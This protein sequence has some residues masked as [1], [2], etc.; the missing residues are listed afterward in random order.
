[1]PKEGIG[2]NFK[3]SLVESSTT[4]LVLKSNNERKRKKRNRHENSNFGPLVPK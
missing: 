1:M 3:F 4:A 2:A